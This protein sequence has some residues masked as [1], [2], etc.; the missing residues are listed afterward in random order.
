MP[1]DRIQKKEKIKMSLQSVNNLPNEIEPIVDVDGNLW[2][3]S[4]HMKKYLG[5]RN[6]RGNYF[7]FSPH[8]TRS[9]SSTDGLNKYE[10]STRSAIKPRRKNQQNKWDIF[11]SSRGLLHVINK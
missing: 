7:D 6:I 10:M 8:Y 4:A 5:I 1:G 9:R 11:L 2:F 3:K